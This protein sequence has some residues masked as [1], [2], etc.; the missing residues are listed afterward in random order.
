MLWITETFLYGTILQYILP[1]IYWALWYGIVGIRNCIPY[2][3]QNHPYYYICLYLYRNDTLPTIIF[4]IRMYS[5][6]Y[7][8]R[9]CQ[10]CCNGY[11]FVCTLYHYHA[12]PP[13]SSCLYVSDRFNI[14][15]CFLPYDTGSNLS[16]MRDNNRLKISKNNLI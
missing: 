4:L 2:H 5:M 13:N 8:I 6:S 15:L 1:G 16:V 7:H 3:T 11:H 12:L 9:C 10:L 14:S